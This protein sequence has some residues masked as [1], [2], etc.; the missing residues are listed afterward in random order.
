MLRTMVVKT[1]SESTEEAV[2]YLE[3]NSYGKV[4]RVPSTDLYV[5]IG[6]KHYTPL[7]DVKIVRMY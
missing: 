7:D 6:C 5:C 4:L 2:N 3:Y 1:W